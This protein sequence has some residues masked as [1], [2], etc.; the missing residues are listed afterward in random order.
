MGDGPWRTIPAAQ[1]AGRAWGRSFPV[2]R[3][4]CGSTGMDEFLAGGDEALL[5][6]AEPRDIVAGTSRSRWA[7][8]LRP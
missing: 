3:G 6:A 2:L 1:E 7:P 8:T 4:S 5:S